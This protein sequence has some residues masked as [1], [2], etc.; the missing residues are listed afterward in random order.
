M[1]KASTIQASASADAAAASTLEQADRTDVLRTIRRA[2]LVGL[3]CF[4][5]IERLNDHA[6]IADQMGLL[7]D[8]MMPIHPSGSSETI[9]EF[10]NALR[11]LEYLELR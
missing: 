2:L 8:G 9:G 1:A 3:A 6:V 5:E 4:G 7:P 10:A 11:E